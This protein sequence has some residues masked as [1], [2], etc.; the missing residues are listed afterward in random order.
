MTMGTLVGSV[1][2]GCCYHPMR[3]LP[4][5]CASLLQS[6]ANWWEGLGSDSSDSLRASVFLSFG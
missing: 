5:F 2:A 6:P 3:P 1:G 4:V